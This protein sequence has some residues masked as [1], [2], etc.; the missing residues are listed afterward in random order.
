[1]DQFLNR[2]AETNAEG[3][4][5]RNQ[6]HNRNNPEI[7]RINLEPL[8]ERFRKQNPPTFEGSTNPLEAEEWLRSVEAILDFMR[9]NDQEKISCATFMFK[10]NARYWW[11]VVKRTKNLREL[12]WNEF[13]VIFNEKYYNATVIAGKT[14]EFNT[15][16]QGSLS[17]V[18][19]VAKFEELAR[20]CPILIPDEKERIRRMILMFRP[21][22]AQFIEA[23]NGAP[24]TVGETIERALRGEFYE[25]KIRQ[26]K[27]A[28]QQLPPQGAKNSFSKETNGGDIHQGN[29]HFK[30]NNRSD[31]KQ[32]RTPM[33]SAIKAFKL[34][35]NG[36]EGFL[37]SIVDNCEDR[38]SRPEDVLVVKDYLEVFPE[39]LLG[40]PPDREI[41]FE[42]ELLPGTQPISKI[43]YHPGKANKVADALSR[44]I[45]TQLL[46]I[47]VLPIPLQREI[48][49]E[50]IEIISGQLS[51]LTLQPTL[52]DQ[53]R[54]D[55]GLDP[56][57]L[58]IRQEVKDGNHP[59][60][61][62]SK[63]GLLTFKDRALYGRKCQSPIHWH[64]AGERK[65]ILKGI[66]EGNLHTGPDIVA[67]TSE[68]IERIRQ[69]MQAAQI[70]ED[71]T[72][73]EKPVQI[74]DRKEKEL[75]KRKI[76]LVKV[77]WRNHA[78]EEATWE[79]EDEMR[80]KHPE[81]F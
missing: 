66:K 7:E 38:R 58:R 68:A 22:I 6:E 24:N 31:P 63:S 39:D 1:M 36:C 54:D 21:E 55:Q 62:I 43:L 13:V 28:G 61:S 5:P 56:R 80:S 74:L 69:R 72:Y 8:Y 29:N 35:A 41:E 45:S 33:I 37:A 2:G 76:L 49:K 46:T 17:V 77:L 11:D 60:F 18:E 64:E 32:S 9:L 30:G 27:G 42:I 65:F 20:F 16:Q 48:I 3:D 14:N 44:K 40:L 12:T 73:E 81:L 75:R 4:Q 47:Q 19:A 34:L 70:N 10:K 26:S 78:T 79:R 25:A 52:I 57:L 50:G 15:I 71:L 59:D 51:T 67:E 53:V 23:R